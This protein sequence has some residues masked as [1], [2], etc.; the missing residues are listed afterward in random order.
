MIPKSD[1]QPKNF[2]KQGWN[3]MMFY[4]VTKQR[5]FEKPTYETFQSAWNSF[6]N[7]AYKHK[8]KMVLVP[9]LASGLDRLEWPQVR[10]MMKS[11]VQ[12]HAILQNDSKSSLRGD[13]NAYQFHLCVCV[14]GIS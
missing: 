7:L 6:L 12:N 14:Y 13:P 11:S 9:R 4:L 3:P 8:I 1:T 5:Y 2:S 10:S